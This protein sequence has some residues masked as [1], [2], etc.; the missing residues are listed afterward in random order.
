MKKFC[1]LI[2]VIGCVQA[3]ADEGTIPVQR[4]SQYLPPAQS[5]TCSSDEIENAVNRARQ[6]T[7]DIIRQDMQVESRLTITSYGANEHDCYE[8]GIRRFRN[9]AV[10]DDAIR[11]CNSKRRL[12]K[13]VSCAIDDVHP[14][15]GVTSVMPTTRDA[16]VNNWYPEDQDKC[17]QN[18][19][20]QA[21]QNA[22]RDCQASGLACEIIQRAS[23][24]SMADNSMYTKDG[25]KGIHKH[26]TVFC[27][28]KA[29]AAPVRGNAQVQCSLEGVARM[30]FLKSPA[31]LGLSS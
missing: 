24:P 8:N 14:V 23:A 25:W 29:T 15:G 11:D 7:L 27:K 1:A 31:L 22:M 28:S 17:V 9:H 30:K 19:M 6:E 21:E 3:F 4:D 5:Q 20:A 18:A 16:Q 13:D 10:G 12:F 26:K 2:L